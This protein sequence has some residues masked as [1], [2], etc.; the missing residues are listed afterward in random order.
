M[1]HLTDQAR[2]SRTELGRRLLDTGAMSPSWHDA[3]QAVDRAGFLPPVMWPYDMAS[4]SS[5]SCDRATDPAR[6]YG[7]ADADVPITTQ[8]DDGHHTGPQAGRVPTSSTSMP[9]VVMRMLR[10]LDVHDGMR[11][12]EIGTGTGWNAAL[13]AHRLGD[14]QVTTVEVDRTVAAAACAALGR[15]GLEPVTVTGDGLLGYPPGAPYDRILATAGMRRIPYEWIAQTVP[16]GLI[17]APWGTHYAN[18]DRLLRLVVSDDGAS[19]SGH[20][21]TA[22]EF[23]KIRSQRLTRPPHHEYAP[24]FPGDAATCVTT[25]TLRADDGDLGFDFLAGLLV[26]DCAHAADRRGDRRSVW[27]YG[28]TDRS[29]AATVLQDGQPEATVYQSGPRRLWDE[30]EAAHRWWTDAGRPTPDRFG[31]TVT[32][33]GEQAWLDTPAHPLRIPR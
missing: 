25:L 30:L 23:M 21:T 2:P 15:A 4:R 11:V 5:V 3:Y 8:W 28:L 6:W 31:L 7:Y 24:D 10:E 1:P 22:V 27:L 18:A 32:R 12:L 17:V 14:R 13:L 29:W 26:P 20:F 16:G 9:S 19:A 33:D